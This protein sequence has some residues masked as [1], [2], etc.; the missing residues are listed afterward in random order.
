MTYPTTTSV[1]RLA[2]RGVINIKLLLVQSPRRHD[3]FPRAAHAHYHPHFRDPAGGTR[4]HIHT[5]TT[6][7]HE[8][9][10]QMDGSRS[11]GSGNGLSP[12]MS[13]DDVGC[14]TSSLVASSEWM[15]PSGPPL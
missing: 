11:T 13:A 9:A 10:A 14:S 2:A 15:K 3:H 7:N 6:D 5:T 12:I 4:G 8:E 1:A